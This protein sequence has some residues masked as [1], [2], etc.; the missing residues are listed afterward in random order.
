MTFSHLD[1]QNQPTMVD[2][3]AKESTHRV[4]IASGKIR[5]GA[6]AYQAILDNTLKKGPVIQTAIVA[7]IMGAKQTSTLIP[8]CHP[9]NLSGVHVQVLECPQ[10]SAFLVR[11]RVQCQGQ[12][13]VEME[14]LT[15]VSVGLL[16]IYDMAKS[17]DKS[18]VMG[19]IQLEQKSGGKS[20][21]YTIMAKE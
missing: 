11:V 8:M 18:M 21:D 2:V 3:S 12:T 17:L 16:T 7:A 6:Q 5:M 13:G 19:E 9:L 15:G 20:G 10:E 4:A 14:A 1:A